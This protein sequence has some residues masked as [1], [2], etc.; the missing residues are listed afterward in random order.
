MIYSIYAEAGTRQFDAADI[1]Q[2]RQ[3]MS[4]NEEARGEIPDDGNAR[5][6]D[7][8]DDLM[9][10]YIGMTLQ[11]GVAEGRGLE[12]AY[13]LSPNLDQAAVEA[14]LQAG[15]IAD[16]SLISLEPLYTLSGYPDAILNNL[17]PLAVSVSG[18][19]R[20]LEVATVKGLRRRL[21]FKGNPDKPAVAR[22][23]AERLRGL[24]YDGYSYKGSHTIVLSG[25]VPHQIIGRAVRPGAQC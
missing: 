20:L 18:P 13:C 10:E 17:R 14:M 22:L 11:L 23:I 8:Y 9:N 4:V 5:H 15:R 12:M 19:L 25:Q 3:L 21:N 16:A 1:H 2:L 6:E 7:E 24:G